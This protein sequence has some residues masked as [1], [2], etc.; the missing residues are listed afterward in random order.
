MV[1]V[2]RGKVFTRTSRR[3]ILLSTGI[4]LVSTLGNLVIF[5]ERVQL[6]PEETGYS[7]ALRKSVREF[8]EL[9]AIE[10]DET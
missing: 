3:C 10:L 4:Y 9:I 2:W 6:R 1:F 8:T 7:A 5:H